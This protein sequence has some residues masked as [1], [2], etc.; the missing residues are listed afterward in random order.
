[1]KYISGGMRGYPRY[2]FDTF[3]AC[4]DWLS[5]NGITSH[6][7]ARIDVEQYGFNPDMGLEEQ[8]F[9]LDAAMTRDIAFIVSPECD[10]VVVLPG[11]ERSVGAKWE[12]GVAQLIGKPVDLWA[13]D[14]LRPVD[15]DERSVHVNLSV[16][17]A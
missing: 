17:A 6:N 11:W 9:D 12:V 5:E 16:R 7:P 13:D 14:T 3:Y 2:N 8:G 10:G 4:E 15:P 1:M